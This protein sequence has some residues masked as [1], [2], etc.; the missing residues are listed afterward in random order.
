MATDDIILKFRDVAAK[1]RGGYT[2][3]P[4]RAGEI[5]RWTIAFSG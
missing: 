4:S 5:Q 1:A 2:T 3:F